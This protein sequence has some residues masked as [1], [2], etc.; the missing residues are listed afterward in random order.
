MDKS[1]EL[2]DPLKTYFYIVSIISPE[3]SHID[4]P[5]VI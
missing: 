2:L 3:A 4:S 5:D 1:Y